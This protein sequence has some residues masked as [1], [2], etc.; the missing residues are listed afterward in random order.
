MRLEEILKIELPDWKLKIIHSGGGLCVRSKK[1]IWID[2]SHL[3]VPFLLH[4]IAHGLLPDDRHNAIWGDKFTAL[5][6]K[7]FHLSS[8]YC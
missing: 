1:E 3:T 7:Y 4:E 6:E 8:H 2:E 5:C